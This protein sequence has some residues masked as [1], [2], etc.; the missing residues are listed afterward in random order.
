MSQDSFVDN[1]FPPNENSLLGKSKDGLYLDPMEA[2]NKI[3]KDSEVEWKRIADVVAK[4][5]IFEDSINMEFVKFGRVSLPYFYCV[6]SALVKYYPSIFT[7]I[8]VSKDYNPQGSYQVQLYIDG[9]FQTI[10]IDDYFPCIRGTNVYYFTRPSNF[11]IWPLLIE[12]AWAKVNGGYLNIVNL[13]PGDFFK[14]LTGFSF[15]E[16]V[17][18]N[19]TKEELFN[20]LA[21]NKGLAFTLSKDDKEIEQ[22]GLYT[23]QTYIVEDAEKVEVDKDKF[24][25]LLKL[26]DA[27]DESNWTGSYSP[28]SELWTEALK[29]KIN[30]DKLELNDGEF[31]ISLDDFH[32]L[33]LRTDV[34]HML[35]DAFTIDFP[36]QA[37]QL[38]TP[39]VFNIVVETEGLV[40]VSILE[41]NW[42]FHRE[43]RN[44]SHPTSLVIAEYDPTTKGIKGVNSKYEN[45]EDLEIT[46]TLRPGYYL[47]WAYKTTDPNEKIPAESMTVKFC[48]TA[49]IGVGFAGDDTNFHLIRNIIYKSLSEK[50]KANIKQDDFFYAVDNSFENS[51]IG[52]QMVINPLNNIYQVWKVDSS[53]THGFLILPPHEKPDVE[54]TI[55][56]QDYE[57]II[58]IKRYKYGKHCL[59]LGVEVTVLKGSTEP[60]KVEAK[61]NLDNFYGNGSNVQLVGGNPTF[62]SAEIQQNQKFPVLD[63]WQLFLEK[64]KNEYPLI[65]EELSKLQPLTDEQFDLN[66]IERNR[67]IYIGEA[68]YGIRFGRGA[69]VFAKEKIT[70]IGYWDKGFQFLKGKVFDKNGKL[71]FEG[72]YKNGVRDGK[73][74][75]NY[76]GGEKYDGT[77]V[78]GLREGKG[79]FTW[80]DQI[81]WE[82]PF[83]NDEMNG[84][85]VMFDGQESYKATFKDGDLVEN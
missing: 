35:T 51:G 39:K 23:W 4:P 34:C 78:N 83:K 42:H 59:N 45:N 61:P 29:S 82:G 85:G 37:G 19:V 26:R 63:R 36:F 79:V 17:H 22:K 21:K 11:Q 54:L 3:I 81:R 72:E 32:R 52:Y 12:K 77:F 55:G 8:I 56:F 16:L 68:D 1:E 76:D 20:E 14:A 57:I 9:A 74:V 64:H 2:R 47:V 24:E 25:Y 10:T 18:P 84:E 50:N 38:V 30:K 58:G 65:I 80:N 69:Y 62:S 48:A 71:V 67:N 13:W 44:I 27:E 40:C 70:Y 49:K 28:K 53:A 73:G 41:K 46:T 31:W 66:I 7:K 15:D 75:Y 5:V 43:L 33:F 6:L 60:P